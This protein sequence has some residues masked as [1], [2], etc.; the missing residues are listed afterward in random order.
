MPGTH[1]LPLHAP[2]GPVGKV[3]WEQ[4]AL[5]LAAQRLGVDVLHVPYWAPPYITP[6]PTL[7]TVH[8]IIPALLPAYRGSWAVRRY[9]GLVSATAKRAARLLTDSEAARSDIIRHLRIP[10]AQV[11]AIY[12]AA[13]GTYTPNASPEDAQ[14]RRDLGLQPGYLLY[15]GGF[16]IRKNLEAVFQAF[17]RVHKAL[18]KECILV[19][20]GKLPEKDSDF[21][22]NPRRLMREAGVPQEA[23][24][25]VGFVPEASKP[26]LYRGAR[27]FFFPSRYEGFGLPPLE[28]MACGTP[29]VGSNTASLPEVV[30]KGG[31]LLAP[32][33][34]D[35][36]AE[37]LLEMLTNDERHEQIAA[38]AL[39]QAARFS[40]KATAA[41]TFAAYREV[42]CR[43]K[44]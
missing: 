19:I 40:W 25:L 32:D 10:K 30:G 26:A 18:G 16:D 34:I 6:V 9:T 31:M 12:L 28:A 24:K 22:P 23:V 35:G 33:N 11:Q 27:V 2:P 38:Q 14:I 21:A 29:V 5:P 15:L 1:I 8:D 4:I 20:A 42:L 43:T 13:D 3:W 41:A 7:V 36:M 37:A 44:S 17:A 39:E